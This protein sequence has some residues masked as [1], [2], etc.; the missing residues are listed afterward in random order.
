MDG[1]NG[2]AYDSETDIE[3]I[4]RNFASL[5]PEKEAAMKKLVARTMGDLTLEEQA[6]SFLSFYALTQK[7]H[8]KT[9]EKLE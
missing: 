9:A 7:H 1:V 2:F 8:Y 6:K 3:K 5:S 4:L